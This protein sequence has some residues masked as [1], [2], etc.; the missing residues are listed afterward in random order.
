MKSLIFSL[1]ALYV[2]TC[3]LLVCAHDVER[4]RIL[5]LS[6]GVEISFNDMLEDLR[7]VQLVFVGERH[8]QAS[9]HEAQLAVIRALRDVGISVAVGLEMFRLSFHK[10]NP[11]YAIVVLAGSGHAWKRGIPEQ[12][13]RRADI[14]YRVILPEIPEK[15]ESTVVTLEDADYIWLGL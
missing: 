1:A 7:G 8:N 4:H 2:M 10:K 5:R 14:S 11:Q 6:D 15:A 13:R 9:H 12:V 3:G